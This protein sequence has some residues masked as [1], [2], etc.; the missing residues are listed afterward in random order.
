MQDRLGEETEESSDFRS[1][2]A[3]LK[4]KLEA[5]TKYV[6]PFLSNGVKGR[7]FSVS[8]QQEGRNQRETVDISI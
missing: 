3:K 2:I 7:T 1:Q 4:E 8:T 5:T 6:S